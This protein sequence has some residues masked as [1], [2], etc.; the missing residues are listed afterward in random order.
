M[1]LSFFQ[2][3]RK[4]YAGFLSSLYDEKTN[5]DVNLLEFPFKKGFIAA[6]SSVISFITNVTVVLN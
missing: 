1:T 3:H 2:K 4:H 6:G 5:V